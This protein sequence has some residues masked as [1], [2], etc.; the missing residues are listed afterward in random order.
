MTRM[1]PTTT[2]MMSAL[3]LALLSS[4]AIGSTAL[5]EIPLTG[6][7]VQVDEDFAWVL[8]LSPGELPEPNLR[9]GR[10]EVK[11][12]F[13]GVDHERLTQPGDGLAFRDVRIRAGAG[14]SALVHIR[15]G[16][17]REISTDDISVVPFEGGSAVRFRRG[18]LPQR[19]AEMNAAADSAEF[20][21][22]TSDL[23]ADL[24]S[25]ATEAGADDES[26]AAEADE[27]AMDEA[28]QSAPLLSTETDGVL[29][30][31]ILDGQDESKGSPVGLLLLVTALLGLLLLFVRV[32]VS[33]R[34]RILP[35]PDI[36][37]ISTK[38]IGP[39]HQLIVVRALGEEHLLSVNGTQTQLIT[40]V[41]QDSELPDDM[42]RLPAPPSTPP[43]PSTP[44]LETRPPVS[45]LMP[46]PARA[47]S[48][49]RFGAR[50]LDL[51]TRRT[52]IASSSAPSSP[53][54]A[55]AGLLELRRRLG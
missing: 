17:R 36:D 20:E 55:V 41:S 54:S 39:R 14:D 48:D 15:F 44:P 42:L 13:R 47:S 21:E 35:A 19:P 33:R 10:G 26:L 25:D 2:R 3:A 32:V 22:G 9:V 11:L 12:W 4:M 18:A 8:L 5:A 29:A 43:R 6:T 1:Q 46:S 23:V 49:E 31:G 7:Q 50:L 51:A 40:S 37:V 16:D 30:G 27:A 53:A 38:R 34:K 24:E 52:D 45:F 28:E